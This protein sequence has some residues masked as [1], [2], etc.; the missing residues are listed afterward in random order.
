MKIAIGSDHAGFELKEIL[1][2]HLKNLGHTLEDFDVPDLS[3]QI[4]L[5]MGTPWQKV[6]NEDIMT[7]VSL[8]AEVG[9]ES[10]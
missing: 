5:I 1:S 2:D 3:G 8:S 4:T 9:M 7:E 10:I 6:Y